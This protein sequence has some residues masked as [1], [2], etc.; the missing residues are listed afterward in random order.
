M[1]V[2]GNF[3]AA[4]GEKFM[5]IGNFHLASNTNLSCPEIGLHKKV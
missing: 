3:T 4:G 5:T 2:S 1:L